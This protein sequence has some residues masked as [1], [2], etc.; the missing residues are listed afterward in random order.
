MGRRSNF[1]WVFRYWRTNY[2]V[3]ESFAAHSL[4]ARLDSVSRK[5]QYESCLSP[6][7]AKQGLLGREDKNC[8]PRVFS[9]QR[10][11]CGSHWRRLY[12]KSC[13]S[14]YYQSWKAFG[15]TC[16]LQALTVNLTVMAYNAA[17]EYRCIR[18]LVEGKFDPSSRLESL[19]LTVLH[20]LFCKN[21]KS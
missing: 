1:G 8:S 16:K 6:L 19:K 9:T 10:L 18:H 7:F 20:R 15:A 2:C 12:Q 4:C 11:A 13:H 14:V 17:Y 21:S 5:V 3:D